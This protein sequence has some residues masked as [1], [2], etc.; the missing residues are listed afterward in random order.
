LFINNGRGYY[1]ER[2]AELGIIDTGQGRGV[3][4][5]DADG[6]GDIDIFVANN[7]D[8]PRF[9]RNEGG[10]TNNYLRLR[11]TSANGDGSVVGTRV[12]AKTG[13]VTQMREVRVGSNFASQNPMEVHFGF[14]VHSKV[15]KLE[16]HWPFG[17]VCTY[18]QVPT[19]RML[20]IKTPKP[21]L[22]K[23]KHYTKKCVNIRKQWRR[24]IHAAPIINP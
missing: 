19:N 15:N 9:Y 18:R 16:I 8:S 6:D 1:T 4:C 21:I 20:V 12:Y 14:G 22:G 11:L 3:V 5:F 24:P 7:S 10:N 23:N 2:S 17:Q 13:K